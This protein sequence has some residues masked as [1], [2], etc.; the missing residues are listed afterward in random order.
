MYLRPR[1]SI[2][3]TQGHS[4]RYAQGQSIDTW[5]YP[6]QPIFTEDGILTC[7]ASRR[8]DLVSLPEEMEFVLRRQIIVR[9]LRA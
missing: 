5:P 7:N 8:P 6:I 2:P 4:L 1:L 9:I 3:V